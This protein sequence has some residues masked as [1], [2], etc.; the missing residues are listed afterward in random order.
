MVAVAAFIAAHREQRQ[1]PHA[2][3][4]RALGVSQ[5]VVLREQQL[6]A[7]AKKRREQITRQDEDRWR[8]PDLIGRDFAADQ[9]DH[10]DTA[11]APRSTPT[12]ASCFSTAC[13]I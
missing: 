6:V 3:A 1:V 12:R 7:R 9:L 11:T 2:T 10:S 4:C 13:W 8:A 5:A